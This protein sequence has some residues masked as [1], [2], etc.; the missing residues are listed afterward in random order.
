MY[1]PYISIF[2]SLY[3]SKETPFSIKAIEVHNRIQVGTPELIS[4]I[5]AIRKGNNEL[6]NTLMAIMFNGTFSERKDD[7]LVEHSGLCILD[8][9]KYPDAETMAA[10]R[11]RLI[12]DKYT[13]MLFTSPSGKGLKVVIRIPQCDKVEHR[14]RF[15]HYEQYINSEYFDTSNKN[16]SRVCFES[17]DPDAYLNEF[18]AIYTGIVEDTGYHRSE[19]TPKVIVTNENRIIEKV[20]KFNHGEFKEGNRANY[21]YKVACCLCEYSIPL[22]TAE[23]TLLQFTQDGF[24]AT[25]IT[26]TVRNAYK[27]AQFGLKVFEDVEAIQGIKNKLKQGIAPEDI[28][29]Q[30]SVS[31]DDI[32]AIQKEEDI[33]WEVKKNTVNIIPN[34]YAA[35]LH[36]QGFAKYYPERSNNP[37]FV[38]ITENKVQE[39]S[40]EKIKDHVLTYLM[41][42]ELMDVYNHCA[43]SSQLFTPGHLNMLDSIDMRILQDSKN[44]CYLPFTN[45]V[46]VITKNKVKLLSY[47]DIDG[48]IWRDQIIPREFKVEDTYENNFQDF[49]NKIAAQDPNRIKSMRT[50]IG[51]LLHTYKDKADQKAVIFNDEEI[52]DNPNGGSG[53]SLML[54]ALGHIR[55]I[56]KI[57]GKLFNPGKNDFVY[58]RVNPDTQVLA[59]DDVKKHFNFEQLFSLITEGIPVNRKNK[60]EYYIPYE[61]S[62]KIVITTNY[63]IA[64]AGGSHDRRRHEVEFNQYFNAN[65]SPIDEY[66]CKLF[67]QWTQE[68][69]SYFDN[70]MIDNIKYYLEHG[71]YQTTGINSDIKKFIQNTCKEFYDFVEDTPLTADGSH[72]HRYKGLMQQFQEE[73]NGFKDLKPQVFARWIDCYATHMKY[74]LTKHRNHEGRHFYLTPTQPVKL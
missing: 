37:I 53:K 14:R 33:F 4:K 8:F 61:R 38:Y 17:Y 52:D 28:S 74:K 66:G 29:K 45:G 55:K 15:S 63:V 13:Y 1:N 54:T 7:G 64:G 71:L 24:G 20:L 68:E 3:N 31:K 56:V 5:K 12:E 50:T 22:T 42:R 51:Y 58:S 25:E 36:K 62:P 9:D 34:K 73:T 18:A 48:Y 60:D 30:L 44:E 23:N 11:K 72:L 47:I 2:K 35:W 69:W 19:Y 40:V 43:K 21:I 46:A 57:D 70:Y 41:E 26:N 10:E 49:V 67:D 59:F 27:Q 6:K 65:H 32:K 39:S 16:I